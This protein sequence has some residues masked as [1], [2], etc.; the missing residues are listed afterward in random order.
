MA[1]NSTRTVTESGT[2]FTNFRDTSVSNRE[3]KDAGKI[4]L[5]TESV[6]QILM[7]REKEDF[8]VIGGVTRTNLP[9]TLTR[10]NRKIGG[11]KVVIIVRH[12]GLGKTALLTIIAVFGEI[13]TTMLAN[14][15]AKKV[16]KEIGDIGGKIRLKEV[17][18]LTR[19]KK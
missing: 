3:G 11:I 13:S 9:C 4:E 10:A 16:T 19:R 15:F 7:F 1:I 12:C 6:S 5:K 8:I 17:S 2:V 14:D 18:L